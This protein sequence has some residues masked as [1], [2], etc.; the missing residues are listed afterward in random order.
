MDK[1]KKLVSNTVIFGIGTFGSKLISILMLRFYTGMLAPAELGVADLI[2]Q[3]ANFL[4]PVATFSIMEAVVRFG[5]DPAYHKTKV[6]SIGIRTVLLGMTG[7]VILLPLVNFIPQFNGYGFLL[8]VYVYISGFKQL[9]AQ[10]V[11]AL[12]LVKLYALD[13]IFT[14]VSLIVLNMIL[15]LGF[16]LGI[17]GYLLSIMLADLLSILFLWK[18]ARLGRYLK[19][20]PIDGKL[21]GGMMRYSLPLIPTAV[22]WI[23]ISVSDRFFIAGMLGNASAGLYTA[24]N[25]LPQA[26]AV[27]STVISQ[28]WQISAVDEYR[29][30]DAAQFFSRVFSALQALLFLG[31]AGILLLLEPVSHILMEEQYYEAIQY[32]PLLII[33]ILMMCLCNF[34]SS[35]YS[36]T[37]HTKNSLITSIIA[38]AVNIILNTLLIPQMGIQGAAVATLAS[39]GV[40]FFIRLADSRRYVRF[41][42][43]NLKILFNLAALGCMTWLTLA[44][45]P[46][47]VWW[48]LL[49]C[50]IIVG[51]NF[52]G[53]WSTFQKLRRRTA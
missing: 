28:A 30:K 14:T 36:A 9:C 46:N 39:Y 7:L 26:L 29:S 13:G 23:V 19:L 44:K 37:K 16:K 3:T 12:G 11:R 25:K 22:L 20:R 21:W 4:I 18:L 17:T 15:M 27:V 53:L 50:V 48:N 10:F 38:A 33:G 5:L 42:V 34:L 43:S 40:C 24:A 51:V 41:R 8:Y 47:S 45:I 2:A 52:R 1:Y 6:F 31:G 32:S 35:I 49:I